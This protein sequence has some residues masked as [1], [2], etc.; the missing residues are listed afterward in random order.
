MNVR[1]IDS[2]AKVSCAVDKYV[3]E[4]VV[5][6]QMQ[7]AGFLRELLLIRDD[8]LVLSKSVNFTRGEIETTVNELCTNKIYVG[9]FLIFNST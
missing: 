6:Q 1:D 9:L 2:R 5:D 8:R 7:E 3:E 4:K